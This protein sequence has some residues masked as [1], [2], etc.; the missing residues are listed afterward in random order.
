MTAQGSAYHVITHVAVGVITDSAGRVLITRRPAHV[1]QG[2]CWEFPGGKLE[3]GE[4]AHAALTRELREELA[5]RPT[6]ACPL[7]RIPFHYP[8]K[9]VLLDVWRVTAFDGEPYGRE[10]QPLRWAAPTELFGYRFPPASHP[11]TVAAMLPDRYVISPDTDVPNAFLTA[12]ERT[13]ETG[14]RLIQLRVRRLPSALLR[15]LAKAA[16]E[17]VRAAG[18]RLLINGDWHLAEAVYAN[19]VHLSADQLRALEGRPLP[20]DRWVAASCHNPEELARACACGVDFAVLSPVCATAS[21]RGREPL[22][23]STFSDWIHDIPIPV[24]A[25]GGLG[26]ADLERAWRARAQGVAAIRGFWCA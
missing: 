25:L 8:K 17:R 10:G 22:G 13:L 16:T 9:T 6:A 1:H 24:Y 12:L 11:I 18:G 23:W 4:D 26:A 15:C 14:A 19:G 2:G 7:I 20:A 3:P 21:H 5:I